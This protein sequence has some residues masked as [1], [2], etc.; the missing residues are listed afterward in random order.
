MKTSENLFH[1][2]RGNIP[3]EMPIICKIFFFA[4]FPYEICASKWIDIL[5][6]VNRQIRN[7]DIIY[8]HHKYTHSKKKHYFT[9]YFIEKKSSLRTFHSSIKWWSSNEASFLFSSMGLS[10]KF[11][12]LHFQFNEARNCSLETLK[13]LK[14]CFLPFLSYS[15]LYSRKIDHILL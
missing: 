13:P 14:N 1:Q 8:D 12:E 5:L 9:F 7:I 15:E 4:I 3:I 2:E 10:L 11:V 6:L